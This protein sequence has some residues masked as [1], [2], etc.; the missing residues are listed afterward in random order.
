MGGSLVNHGGQNPLEASRLG[1]KIV[2]GPNTNNFKDIYKLLNRIK[3]SHK[4][5]NNKDLTENIK[6]NIKTKTKSNLIIK[7]I[8]KMGVRIKRLTLNEIKQ[9][10]N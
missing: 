6:I 4:V 7:K 8:E 1:C 10:I 9:T 5:N 3:I 2:H